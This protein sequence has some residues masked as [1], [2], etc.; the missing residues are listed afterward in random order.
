MLK[1]LLAAILICFIATSNASAFL[2][3]V[4]EDYVDNRVTDEHIPITICE[5]EDAPVQITKA[6]ILDKGTDLL[7]IK[8]LEHSFI[9]E[10]TNLSEKE[11]LSYQ[12]VWSRRLP[13]ADYD[14]YQMRTNSVSPVAPGAEDKLV[15]RKPI[16]YRHDA[17][18]EACVSKVMFSDKEEWLSEQYYD[19]GGHWSSIKQE[20]DSIE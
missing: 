16:H 11:V 4:I 19:V 5:E 10:A 6:K 3:D 9:T 17:Y 2:W 20:L 14:V 7:K 13:F 18:Y 12:I 15:F 8:R 1:N